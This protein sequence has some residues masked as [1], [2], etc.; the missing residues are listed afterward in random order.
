MVLVTSG[1]PLFVGQILSKLDRE[2]HGK[3]SASAKL[4]AAMSGPG[5]GVVCRRWDFSQL[6]LEISTPKT[7]FLSCQIDADWWKLTKCTK[8]PRVI[9]KSVLKMRHQRI[10]IASKPFRR[11]PGFTAGHFL[12]STAAPRK[13]SAA[14]AGVFNGWDVMLIGFGVF[15]TWESW[16]KVDVWVCVRQ[17]WTNKIVFSFK[18]SSLALCTYYDSDYNLYT[19]LENQNKMDIMETE[20]AIHLEKEIPEGNWSI[21]FGFETL[22]GEVATPQPADPSACRARSRPGTAAAAGG[23][24]TVAQPW[25]QKCR[26]CRLLWVELG[27]EAKMDVEHN[28]PQN[29]YS[30]RIYS[31][32]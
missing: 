20:H 1:H 9:S 11:F 16:E 26:L 4:V 25:S 23:W 10:N 5:G 17:A 13:E 30:T 14:N 32:I 18:W 31:Y 2:S 6:E 28:Q 29:F 7:Y 22:S 21:F 8:N 3:S 12:T 24:S 27:S 19:L 15:K